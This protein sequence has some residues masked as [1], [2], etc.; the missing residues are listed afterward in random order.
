MRVEREAVASSGVRVSTSDCILI[1]K[2]GL[3]RSRARRN[4]ISIKDC[5]RFLLGS[6]RI[7]GCRWG[8]GSPSLWCVVDLGDRSATSELRQ[9]PSS[10]GGQQW[11]I[12]GNG[13]K[14][15]PVRTHAWR[16]RIV[17]CKVLFADWRNWLNRDEAPANSV[18]AAAARRR[19]RALFVLIGCKGYVGGPQFFGQKSG[20]FLRDGLLKRG[21][22][23][24]IGRVK[25]LCRG[26][27][28]RYKNESQ[29]AKAP[30][31]L[32]QTL[33]YGSLGSKRD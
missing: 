7:S 12:L 16:M 14:P 31:P 18:P 21:L 8:N 3:C 24:E 33:R 29:L 28:L 27:I 32:Q 2:I 10:Y 15:D 23:L 22:V 30:L 17:F 9:G 20:V 26:N 6:R 1:R 19:A 5:Y 25:F 13:R 11:R 4:A